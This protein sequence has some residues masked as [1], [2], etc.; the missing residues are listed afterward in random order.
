MTITI[1]LTMALLH[2]ISAFSSTP[3]LC[4]DPLLDI[5]GAPLTD[6]SGQ[7]LSRHCQW[8]GPDAPL[9]DGA[10]CCDIDTAD[11]ASCMAPNE[12]GQC[13]DGASAYCEYGKESNTG[14][15]ICYQPLP[16]AC[17]QQP[18]GG[19]D[20]T[21]NETQADVLCCENGDCWEFDWENAAWS[22]CLGYFSW[23]SSGFLNE[24]G[25]VDCYD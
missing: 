18:C 5:S 17:D 15:V 11:T 25:S 7:T 13:S 21:P 6:S 22:D 20:K 23:C 14:D 12:R 8:T 19:A 1:V 10:V 9:W 24:D 16:S 3:D 2:S 4:T